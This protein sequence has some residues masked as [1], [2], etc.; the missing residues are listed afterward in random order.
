MPLG[1]QLN[2][3]EG[4]EGPRWSPQPGTGQAQEWEG[5]EIPPFFFIYY[6]FNF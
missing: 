4:Q 2:M 5:A 1:V 6:F 3:R